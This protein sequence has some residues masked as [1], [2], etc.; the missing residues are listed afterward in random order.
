[1]STGEGQVRSSCGGG[2]GSVLPPG[3]VEAAPVELVRMRLDAF[4]SSELEVGSISEAGFVLRFA[5]DGLALASSTLLAVW[6]P[7]RP[8]LL[9][10]A[11]RVLL[12][13]L[14]LLS[15]ELL[16]SFKGVLLLGRIL[17]P[18]PRPLR[19]STSLV[20]D[21]QNLGGAQSC[22]VQSSRVPT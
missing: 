10:A 16:L 11:P 20:G 7:R 17:F 13:P 19:I 18:R 8:L 14:P 9:A 3:R 2:R 6:L 15:E 12:L 21:S 5:E 4:V 22:L 1:M